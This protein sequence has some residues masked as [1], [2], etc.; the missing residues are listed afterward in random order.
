MDINAHLESMSRLQI[1]I[2]YLSEFCFKWCTFLRQVKL[3]ESC[4]LPKNQV[5]A[6]QNSYT[7]DLNLQL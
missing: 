1:E 2:F 4:G 7:F 3:R 6:Y 5:P